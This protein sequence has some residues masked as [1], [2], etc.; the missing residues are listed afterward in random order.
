MANTSATVQIASALKAT[1]DNFNI[2]W[3]STIPTIWSMKLLK[4]E[5]CNMAA[6]VEVE[7]SKTG[8]KYGHMYDNSNPG[9]NRAV[10]RINIWRWRTNLYLPMSIG[11][12]S[13]KS[14]SI[15]QG[16]FHWSA[17]WMCQEHAYA[18]VVSTTTT[19]GAT[20]AATLAIACKSR[21]VSVHTRVS[22]STHQWF[23]QT[24]SHILPFATEYIFLCRL[25]HRLIPG[26][27]VYRILVH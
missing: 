17:E 4:M 11:K 10:G 6:L 3:V 2:T 12:H 26:D 15:I 9:G 5:L 16:P 25:G 22:R 13:W 1:L 24:L 21:H 14:H 19:G 18:P 7:S 27:C 8:G 23:S 20:I